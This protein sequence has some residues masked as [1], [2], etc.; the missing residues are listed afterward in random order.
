MKLTILW[1]TLTSYSVAFFRALAQ[2]QG[3]QLQ[4]VYHPPRRNAP[5][6]GFDLEFCESVLECDTENTD[7]GQLLSFVEKFRPDSVLMASWNFPYFMYVALKM[8]IAGVLV[9][10]TIDHQWEGTLRQRIGA[11]VSP[12]LLKRRIDT[13]LVA[14]DRQA[15][16]AQRLGY[17]DVMYGLY[18]GEVDRYWCDA[19]MRER[20]PAF[21]FVGRLVEE[22]GVRQLARAYRQYRAAT[23]RPWVLRVA[24]T[25]PLRALLE[26]QEGVECQG[27]VQPDELPAL[28]S[29]ARCLVFP[30][31]WEPWGVVVHEG[32]AA[33]LPVIASYATGAV[34]YFVRDGV[35]GHIVPPEPAALAQAMHRVSTSAASEIERMGEN[36]GM[37][38]KLWGPRML[39]NYFSSELAVRLGASR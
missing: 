30:S 22:K 9:V 37:L 12:W 34:T 28:M 39:A 18:A 7:R 35:N 6:S 2:E 31:T 29:Q 4:L 10:S 3:L 33:H 8:K 25:G 20:D 24:G 32:A 26:D 15:A 11:L 16:F 17:Q 38:S 21:L 19:P 14:G 36:S 27:F 1:S 23:P 13:F 5:Y